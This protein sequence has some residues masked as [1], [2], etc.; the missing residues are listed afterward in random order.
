MYRLILALIILWGGQLR[1]GT[2]K[3]IEAGVVVNLIKAD[4][5]YINAVKSVAP[6]ITFIL[7][8]E[9]NK[10]ASIGYLFNGAKFM[11]PLKTLEEITREQQENILRQKS[12]DIEALRNEIKSGCENVAEGTML[13][14]LCQLAGGSQ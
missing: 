10:S 3:V 14:K 2:Y 4:A 7:Q 8:T 13:K 12:N 9:A 6:R 5:A 1:A 11:A